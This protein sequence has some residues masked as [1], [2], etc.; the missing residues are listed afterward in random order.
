MSRL[1]PNKINTLG[2]SKSG[3]SN[4]N[5]IHLYSEWFRLVKRIVFQLEFRNI[6]LKFL[7]SLVTD[8]VISFFFSLEN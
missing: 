3:V 4:I 5:L 6:S 8:S 2:T 1:D 7:L